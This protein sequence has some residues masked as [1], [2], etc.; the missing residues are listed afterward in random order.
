MENGTACETRKSALLHPRS[1]LEIGKV[2]FSEN[3]PVCGSCVV[4]STREKKFG[5]SVCPSG[6]LGALKAM[7][8]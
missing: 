7:V 3:A 4:V 8:N 6:H 1:L 5:G 2:T